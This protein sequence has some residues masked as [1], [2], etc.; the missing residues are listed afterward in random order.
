MA[1]CRKTRNTTQPATGRVSSRDEFGEL[2]DIISRAEVINTAKLSG[3]TVT[4]GTT[5]ALADEDTDEESTYTIVG[6]YEADIERGLISTSSPI[7]RALIGKR[8]SDSVEVAT[9]RGTRSYEI[10][11]IKVVSG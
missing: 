5:V 3:E 11:S 7:A 8:V 1:I 10:L 6:P 4:F 9:P 2:E